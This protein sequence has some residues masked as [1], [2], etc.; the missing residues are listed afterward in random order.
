M[1][2]TGTRT[3]CSTLPPFA[4]DADQHADPGTKD[5]MTR[6][7]RVALL[8]EG[9]AGEGS[10]SNMERS[11]IDTAWNKTLCKRFLCSRFLN[12]SST[13]IVA[14]W[15]MMP[16][17]GEG[18][19]TRIFIFCAIILMLVN[20][21]GYAS[22]PEAWSEHERKV[23]ETC[24]KASGFREAKAEGD[25]MLFPD[26]VGYSALFIRGHYPQLHMKNREG[27]VLCMFNRSTN[28]AYVTEAPNY[29]KLKR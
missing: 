14:S 22:P 15:A 11:H 26:E 9:R 27:L 28:K 19:M 3:S 18:Q 4:R 24:T 20:T 7:V 2:A 21:S 16:R 8:K 1:L 10:K 12:L 17:N 5:E 23:I 29:Q 13:D 25:I 6:R